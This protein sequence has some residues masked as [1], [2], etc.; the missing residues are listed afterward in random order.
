[1][2]PA[3]RDGDYVFFIPDSDINN[4]DIV[5]VVNEWGEYVLKR[6]RTKDGEVYL[7]SDNPEYPIIKLDNGYKILGKVL[8]AWRKVKI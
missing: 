4:G 5:A 1:M 8:A 2:S 3:M 6:Y 7:A